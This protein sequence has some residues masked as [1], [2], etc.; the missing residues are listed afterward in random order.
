ML[1]AGGKCSHHFVL[2]RR[3]GSFPS[4]KARQVRTRCLSDG[5]SCPRSPLPARQIDCGDDFC[6]RQE[7]GETLFLAC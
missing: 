4:R 2:A 3:S 5:R 7:S 6:P 1:G